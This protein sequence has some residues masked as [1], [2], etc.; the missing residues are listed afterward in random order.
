[1][2]V[3][4]PGGYGQFWDVHHNEDLLKIIASVYESGGV[5]G[6]IGHGTA[7]LINVKLKSGQY[8]VHGKT[9]TCFPSWNEKN[10]MQ[11]SNFGKLLPFDMEEELKKKG[12]NLKI[13]NPQT[14]THHE[15]VDEEGRL[16]TAAFAGSGT[17]LASEVYKLIRKG[18]K[19]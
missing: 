7:T 6:T 10:I 13:Y 2:A 15:I 8:L 9:M 18:R 3:I 5:V 17:F 4:I 16:V 11:Q 19:D 12:A 14:R 1:M